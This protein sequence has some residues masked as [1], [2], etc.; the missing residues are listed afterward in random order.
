MEAKK[1]NEKAA[2]V[3][4]FLYQAMFSGPY[5]QEGG[6]HAKFEVNKTYQ[7]VSVEVIWK[8]DESKAAISVMH[9]GEQNGDLMRDPDVTF[10][11]VDEK[12]FI[13]LTFQNDYAGFYGEYATV[14]YGAITL[15]EPRKQADLASFC[16]DWMENIN[17]QQEL[18]IA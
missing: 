10:L 17:E 3:L 12:T 7:P 1:V 11:R 5:M 2:K 15:T 8:Y 18:N 9:Y 6:D 16:N 14:E 13:P 4:E